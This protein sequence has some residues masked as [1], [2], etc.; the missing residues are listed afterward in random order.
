MSSHSP[1]CQVFK[2]TIQ[3]SSFALPRGAITES[4][5]LAPSIDGPKTWQHL[6]FLESGIALQWLS[7]VKRLPLE[8]RGWNIQ[9]LIILLRNDENMALWP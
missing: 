2:T 5:Q 8:K 7:S 4:N 6:H 1:P 9:R 3:L